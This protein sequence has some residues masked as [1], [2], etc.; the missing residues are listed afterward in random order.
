MKVISPIFSAEI[1]VGSSKH[2]RPKLVHWNEIAYCT[3]IDRAL[4]MQFKE[5]W[6][7]FLRPT[8]PELWKFF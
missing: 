7:S 1:S 4:K 8:I 2:F 6:G 3:P 5:G